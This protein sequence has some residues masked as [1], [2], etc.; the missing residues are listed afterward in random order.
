MSLVD[1][2]LNIS[3]MVIYD[4][5]PY[6]KKLIQNVNGWENERLHLHLRQV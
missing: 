1:G 2:V 6:A 4:H 5:F 3:Y